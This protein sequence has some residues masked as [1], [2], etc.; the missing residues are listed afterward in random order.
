MFERDAIV[1][2][3]GLY[4]CAL[5]LHLRRSLARR[6][7]LLEAGQDLVGRASW[8]NQARVHAGYHYP[9]SLLTAYRSRVNYGH[10]LEDFGDCIDESFA[11]YYAIARRFSKVTASQFVRFCERIG[12][13]L[14]DAPE[15]VRELFDPGLV[16]DVFKVREVAFDADKL[17]AKFAHE[18]EAEGVEVWRRCEASRIARAGDDG[19]VLTCRHGEE[20]V[21][22]LAGS[23]FNCTYSR[24]NRLLASSG[25][26]LIPLKHELTEIALVEVPE[27]LR[28]IGVTVMCGPFFSTMPFPPRGLHSLSHVRY[29]P[30]C[31]WHDGGGAEY[32]DPYERLARVRKESAFVQM[33]RDARRY[34]PALEDCRHV[35][36]IWE[37]K[38]VLPRS[39]LD[40]S[41]PILYRRDQGLPGLT[42]ILGSKIDN[43]YDMIEFSSL[44]S[45]GGAD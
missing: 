6:T 34:L 3:G 10:F 32:E 9:R 17:R 8:V 40:D 37:V 45:C 11:K 35:E 20:D 13:P 44:S 33:V 41:R 21:E 15:D 28:E 19:L 29:T 27:P 38:A 5:A 22:V 39:E 31:E 1:I 24:L 4:G 43:M 23:V 42:C 36:S 2:G 14:E 26:P 16:E 30:H 18:L 7:L 25:L 12:A